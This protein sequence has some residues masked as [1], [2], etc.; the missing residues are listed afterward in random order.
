MLTAARQSPKLLVGVRISQGSPFLGCVQQTFIHLTFNQNRKKATCY[1]VPPWCNGS[2]TG[3]EL[4]SPGSIPGG[5][6]IVFISGCRIVEV[7]ESWILEVQVRFLPPRPLVFMCGGSAIGR[8][9]QS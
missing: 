8:R 9:Q 5:G 3:F 4:V 7:D 1:F 6:A 2:T